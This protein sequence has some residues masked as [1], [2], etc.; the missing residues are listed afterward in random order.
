MELKEKQ[1][2]VVGL[3]RSG[4]EASRFLAS[5]AGRVIATDEAPQLADQQCLEELR[6]SGVRLELG[7]FSRETFLNSDLIILS[8][9]VPP[10]REPLDEAHAAGIEIISE[11]EL[12]CRH[13]R[14]PMLAVTGTN[15][16]TTTTELL[17][18]MF[19]RAGRRVTVA[20]NIGIPLISCVELQRELNLIVVEVS[21][22]Q[23][24]YV[25]YFRPRI[26]ILLNVAEDHLD[27]YESLET[28][29]AT[30]ARIFSRQESE[31]FAV[32]NLE[33]PLVRSMI[34]S[35]RAW[36]VGIGWGN[37]KAPCVAIEDKCIS[38]RLTPEREEIYPL[39]G[40]RL[41]GHHN[42][43]NM[44]AAL[45]AARLMGCPPERAMEAMEKF[46]ALE[47]RLEWVRQINGVD[48]YN[49]SKA[50]NAAA[51]VRALQ[52]FSRPV[53]LLAGGRAKGDD[54]TP[55]RQAVSKCVR[56]LILFGEAR[57]RL[58]EELDGAAPIEVV[59]SLEEAVYLASEY[60]VPH[61][62][63]LMSPACAS[64]DAFT[65]FEHRGKFFK[66]TVKCLPESDHMP[67]AAVNAGP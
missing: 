38:F 18:Q 19:R 45:A 58:A 13:I 53:I 63:V 48:Y 56:Q 23:L 16:K 66:E 47:H 29:A 62:V 9:G 34:P 61:D 31:D 55:L 41:Q 60:A 65:N 25:R 26:S 36:V 7:G 59:S 10:W 35:I 32:V 39:G 51:V 11:I 57:Y 2:L 49:D 54:M 15:G 46:S 37:C 24:E 52:G 21:S 40:I 44:A 22:F 50:T 43:E 27:R 30:K 17:G 33:D 1:V 64:F 28:Y 42:L 8:P 5:R 4:L 12:A 6:S 67:R 14:V 20:G 3:G